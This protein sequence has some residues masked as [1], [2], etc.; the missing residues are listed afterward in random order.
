MKNAQLITLAEQS[1]FQQTGRTDE[2]ER[3]SQ[4]WAKAWPDSVKSIEYG[5]SAEGRPMRA[6]VVSR[7][8]ALTPEQ[9]RARRIPVLMIQGGIH[10]GESDGKD[11]GFISLREMLEGSVVPGVLDKIAILFVPA[12]NTDGHERTG[13]RVS[14]QFQ[15]DRRPFDVL[16]PTP[17][18][19]GAAEPAA[20]EIAGGVE[21]REDLLGRYLPDPGIGTGFQ[22]DTSDLAGMGGDDRPYSALTGVLQRRRVVFVTSAV[23][24]AQ[25]DPRPVVAVEG[26]AVAGDLGL[27]RPAPVVEAGLA[28]QHELHGPPHHANHPDHEMTVGGSGT[29]DGHEVEHLADAVG[30]HEAGDQDGRTRQI[31]LFGHVVVGRGRDA[32]VT[33]PVGVQQRR[34]DAR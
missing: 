2:V 26:D 3:L 29:R 1:N 31:K 18:V 27:V 14:H 19:T 13:R 21:Q 15:G 11:A 16:P 8:G 12:F 10:P 6:L 32:E 23:Q 24:D 9:I 30:R 17:G 5:R 22:H 20:P 7:T 4:E 34:E 33:A 28:V 25:G